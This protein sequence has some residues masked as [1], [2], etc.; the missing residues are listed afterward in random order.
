MTELVLEI[1]RESDLE[2]LLP[3]LNRL[4]IK[5]VSRK[6][7]RKPS[8]K[9]VEE[10]IRVIRAGADFSNLGDPVEWQR[11][12]RRERELPFLNTTES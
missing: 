9:E 10:A 1:Q 3:I 11:E 12:Q 6:K 4:K 8:S 5:Y 7:K 2:E